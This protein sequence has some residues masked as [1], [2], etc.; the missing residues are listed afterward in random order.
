[1]ILLPIG[2]QDSAVRRLPWV[3]FTMM[4]ACLLA[5]LLTNGAA[6]ESEEASG[7]AQERLLHVLETWSDSPYLTLDAHA[8]GLLPAELREH[9]EEGHADA[10]SP[11]LSD[12]EVAAQQA[13]LDAD[14]EAALAQLETAKAKDPYRKWGLVPDSLGLGGLLTHMFMH[15]GWMH[16]IGNLFMLFMAGP[17][18]EDRW[19]RPLYAGFYV[20]SGLASGLFFAAFSKDPNLPLV[21]ASG[22]IA[23][24][25]GAFL[26]RLG[27]TQIRFWYLLAGFGLRFF[28]GTFE[29]PAWVMLPLWFLNELFQAW[30]S[31]ALGVTGGVAYEAH[32]GGFLFG[33]A[34]ALAVKL[35][36]YEE[37]VVDAAIEE[38][39]TVRGN[40]VVAEALALR[41]AGDVTGALQKLAAEVQRQPRDADAVDAYWDAALAGGCAGDAA[42]AV[43]ALAQREL[44]SNAAERAAQR[45]VE[46]HAALPDYGFDASFVVR[47]LP[48]L[49]ALDRELAARA[50]RWLAAQGRGPL[51][52]T[53]AQRA[54]EEARA[55]D[56]AA[57]KQLARRFAEAEQLPAEQRARFAALASELEA[58]APDERPQE[59]SGLALAEERTPAAAFRSFV[60]AASEEAEAGWNAAEAFGP[61]IEESGAQARFASLKVTEATPLALT[62]DALAVAVEGGR[63]GR[64]AFAKIDGVAL[65]AVRGL[66][67]KPVIL[68]DLLVGYRSL[69][70][71]ELRCVR[72][73][74]DR[75]DPRSLIPGERDPL[76]ALRALVAQLALRSG[77]AA[78]G[79]ADP[80]R[81]GALAP[82]ADLASY[83]REVLE[84]GS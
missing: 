60:Q 3:T 43:L 54:V 42:H 51:S 36:R 33:A 38:K 13:A 32:I 55:L 75:F 77:G 28:H 74:S 63:K 59:P 25:L 58:E 16:L 73:R 17:A 66:A 26:V 2:H 71:G 44:S 84:V 7:H 23:G 1:V 62:D 40:P 67:A 4:G 78:L 30:L 29:S 81:E 19:G 46:V 12:D 82:H 41:E 24:V 56:P 10:E 68:V 48:A 47:L 22:A 15:A 69:E 18:L 5:L 14:V 34:A 37:R 27:S 45:F 65:A 50:L 39:I 70:G 49:R 21:G 80:A 72:L 64:L 53:L 76:A 83:E 35:S 79:A 6:S 8:L 31:S 61:L 57:A 52:P 9:Y 20:A 11:G